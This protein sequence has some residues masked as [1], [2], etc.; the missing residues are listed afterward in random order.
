MKAKLWI[1]RALFVFAAVFIAV[2]IAMKVIDGEEITASNWLSA[3]S[4]VVAL[5]ATFASRRK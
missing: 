5:I 1:L 2:L 3:I 4:P